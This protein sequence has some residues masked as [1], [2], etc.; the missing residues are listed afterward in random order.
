MKIIYAREDFVDKNDFSVNKKI[1]LVGPTPRSTEV[2][3]WR[4]TFIDLLSKFEESKDY[5]VFVP[6]NRDG[7]CEMDYINQV[8]WEH[9]F[10]N[11]ANII[12]AWVPRELNTMPAF[13]TN[14][15]F[16]YFIHTGKI[17]Y[18]RPEGAPKTKYLDWL[19]DHEMHEKPLTT[20]EDLVKEVVNWRGRAVWG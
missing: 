9:R 16:G 3:S 4:P 18:G 10:L 7:K 1:F 15:E 6:E 2:K 11:Y 8:E 17:L 14:V 12:A 19:Y 20:M 13:T 5:Y